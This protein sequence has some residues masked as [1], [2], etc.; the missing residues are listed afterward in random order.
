MKNHVSHGVDIIKGSRW[1]M[2]ANDIVSHHHE[3]YNGNGYS[4]NKKTLTGK[5]IPLTAR[6]FAIADVFDA[7]TSRRPYKE[8][9]DFDTTMEEMEKNVNTHFD[10]ELFTTFKAFIY[11][12]RC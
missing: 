3:K 4:A 8:P 1:L 10:P 11:N 6:I 2:D 9:F 12:H 7:L 5:N